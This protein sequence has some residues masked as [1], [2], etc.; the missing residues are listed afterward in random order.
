MTGSATAQAASAL[1][2]DDHL[3]ALLAAAVAVL[4][5]MRMAAWRWLRHRPGAQA[6][7]RAAWSLAGA[8]VALA[9][10]VALTALVVMA[11]ADVLAWD[12]GSAVALAPYRQPWLVLA[13]LWLT[14]FGTGAALTGIAATASGFLWTGSGRGLALPLW[15]AFG[16]AEAT[17]WS[18]KFAVDRA[19]P[20]FLPGVASAASPSFPSAHAT[21]AVAVLGFVA[22][23]VTRGMP[24]GRGRFETAFWTAVAIALVA[25][26]RVFLSVHFASDVLAGLAAGAM[27]LLLGIAVAERGT[28][29]DTT[30]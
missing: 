25:F 26:S 13:F 11:P 5:L 10:L 19:R 28:G 4:V 23:A 8:A 18:L 7:R 22:Y 2:S 12:E 29:R 24:S 14:T 16:G 9:L 15:L 30:S 1:V 6:R 3:L 27:W 20:A 21:G 17:V